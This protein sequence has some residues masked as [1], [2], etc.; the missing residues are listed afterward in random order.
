MQD[1][2]PKVGIITGWGE[3]IGTREREE[4]KVNFIIRKPFDFFELMKQIDD[5]LNAK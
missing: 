1:N 2:R 4:V 3:R 5:T